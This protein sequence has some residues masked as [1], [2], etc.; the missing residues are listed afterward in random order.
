MNLAQ[1]PEELQSNQESQN[2][3]QTTIVS[4]PNNQEP[5]IQTHRNIQGM[6]FH[7]WHKIALILLTFHGLFGLFE[8]VK[9]LFIEYPELNHMLELH[10]INVQEVNH[11]LAKVIIT[12][13]VTFV[14]VLF[15][16]RLSKV[17]E[18]TAHNI[19]LLVATFLIITTQFIQKY[20]IQLDLLNL[21]LSL[22]S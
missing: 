8:S 7:W 22:F 10:Q 6:I 3:T 21:V 9:F 11:L 13:V 18:T 4:Q 2:Q 1:N 17:T 20:L 19:D 5:K 14:T 15:A 12:V 16:I